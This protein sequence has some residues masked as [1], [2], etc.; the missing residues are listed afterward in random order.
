MLLCFFTHTLSVTFFVID[1][2]EQLGRDGADLLISFPVCADIIFRV[3][4][5]MD[6]QGGGRWLPR[7]LAKALD[8]SLL[9]IVGEVVLL[10]EVY[11]TTGQICTVV[12][13]LFIDPRAPNPTGVSELSE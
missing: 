8:K 7:Q 6:V 9:Q 10:P 13:K 5:G 11:D 4:H 2:H 3:Q 1:L 12:S